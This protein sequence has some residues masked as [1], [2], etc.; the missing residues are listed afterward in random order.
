MNYTRRKEGEELAVNYLQILRQVTEK[1]FPKQSNGYMG[2]QMKRISLEELLKSHLRD[3]YEQQYRFVR[4]LLEQEKIKPVKA[5]GTNGKRPA[6]YRSYWVTKEKKDYSVLEEELKYRLH[7]MI[8]VDYYLS[9]LENYEKD[10]EFVLLLDHY[11]RSNQ[12]M[13]SCQES[14]N[15]RSFEIWNREKFLTK[16]Q[17]K[18]ILKCCGIQVE[19]LNVYRTAE[20]LSY[21]SHTR[22]T[23]QKLLIL[24]NK[25]T[26]YSMRRHLLEGKGRIFG[27]EIGTLIYGAGKR[28]LKS[29]EDFDFC[30]E[31]YMAETGN[32]IYYFGDLDFEGIGIYE[33]LAE[34][35]FARWEI[36]PFV[37][38]Y[39]KMLEKAGRASGLPETREKQNRN[40]SEV[41]FSY[42]D[43]ERRKQMEGIL[44][45]EKYIPQE[46]LNISDF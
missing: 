44:E 21:Y 15:E 10:R 40:I 32:K 8:S 27:E 1:Q 24:E 3:S 20:P 13:L 42:F 34:S 18:R 5:S 23:P 7:P 29:F 12:E 2:V 16:E 11:L 19:E 36:V 9:H 39:E 46:I 41:F 35:F 33:K 31:P 4:R 43:E 6:L 37:W 28:I 22:K 45:K 26:F 17:G 25:D 14:V 38:A 30:V